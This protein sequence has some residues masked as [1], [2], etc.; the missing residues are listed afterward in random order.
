MRERREG[1]GEG[2][3]TEEMRRGGIEGGGEIGSVGEL[4]GCEG[5]GEERGEGEEMEGGW[6]EGK[7]GGGGELTLWD[8]RRVKGRRFL[9]RHSRAMS[10]SWMS[11]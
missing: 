8:L 7:R 11:Y 4:F 5:R 3:E 6:G 10:M 2:G 9:S 1:F